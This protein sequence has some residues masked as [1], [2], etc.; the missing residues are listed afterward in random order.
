MHFNIYTTTQFQ[1][2]FKEGINTGIIKKQKP[3]WIYS[4]VR[5]VDME[6]D[7]L[8]KYFYANSRKQTLHFFKDKDYHINE[9]SKYKLPSEEDILRKRNSE[10]FKSDKE[11]VDWFVK[12]SKGKFGVREQV[13]D[14]LYRNSIN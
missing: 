11:F 7:I 8:M 10:N 1:P 4:N 2:E 5:D 14:T 13:E 3:Q 12:E 6:S 9:F